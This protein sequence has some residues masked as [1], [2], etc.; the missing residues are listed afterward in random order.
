MRHSLTKFKWDVIGLSE[1]KKEGKEILETESY[2]MI[3][4]GEKS[5]RNGVGF[6][7]NKD[8]K[9]N[10]IDIRCISDRVIRLDIFLNNRTMHLIQCYAPTESATSEDLEIFYKHLQF[11][12]EDTGNDTV[13]MGDFNSK[14]GK[15]TAE[16]K[17]VMGPWGF[18][19]RNERGDILLQ[20]CFENQLYIANSHFKKNPKQK[21]TWI[22]PNGKVRNEIDFILVKN[23]KDV[24]NVQVINT[25]FPTDHRLIRVSMLQNCNKTKSRR[26]YRCK[27]SKL[28][29]LELES[30]K[31]VF[32]NHISN[33]QCDDMELAYGK[34]IKI[35]KE[36]VKALPK[37]KNKSIAPLS[38]Y[39]EKLINERNRLKNKENKTR[40]EKKQLSALYRHVNK[41]IQRDYKAHRYSVIEEELQ[42]RA[43]VKRA[44]VRLNTS[45]PWIM[46]LKNKENKT[47]SN[48]D[49]LIGAATQFYKELYG[50]EGSHQRT[51]QEALIPLSVVPS[52][53]ESE[54]RCAIQHLKSDK[55]PGDDGITNDILKAIIDPLVP[56]LTS[57][58]NDMLTLN[59]VPKEWGISII[60]LLYKKGDP[61]DLGNYRPISLQQTVYKVFAKVLLNR[62]SRMLDSNQPR[63]QAGFRR[64]YSTIDHIFTLTQLIEKFSEYGKKLYVAFIDYCKAFDS[65]KHEP[66]WLALQTQGV[67]NR[68]IEILKEIYKNSKAVVKLEGK[69]EPFD[70]RRGVKQGDPISPNLF[71][72]LLEYIF[73]QLDWE[74]KG[75][76]LNG[77]YLSNLRFADDIVLISENHKDLEY[78]L[79]TL[80]VESRKCGLQMNKQKTF[81]MTNSEKTPIQTESHSIC[82]VDEYVYLGQN[83]SF[84]NQTSREVERR[85]K[86][87]WNKY[88]SL[89]EIFKSKI[90]MHLKRK[91]MDT[92]VMPTLL[93]GCQTWSFTKD[94]V[95][96][97]NV[98]QRAAERSML[99][100]RLKDRKKNTDIRSITK[101]TDAVEL[102]SRLKWRWAGHTARATDNRWSEKILH[103]YPYEAK[104]PRGR[105]R[106]RWSDDIH[107]VA[108][109]TWTRQAQ[110]RQH[111]KELEEAYAQKWVAQ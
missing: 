9:T 92:V 25:T 51:R 73:R 34:L 87:A 106:R 56:I 107:Q 11:A 103:W 77:E 60:T 22:S 99:G 67:E 24:S 38:A 55:S 81:A 31:N 49:C 10:I 95:Q 36:S 79:N 78:M 68:Y 20:F 30:L 3:Y 91:A 48:R 58:F 80:D 43:S 8:L 13:V 84:L 6:L 39:V 5:G 27:V 35:I 29:P 46:S 1:V 32:A 70:I 85:I 101:I 75:I 102:A 64:T 50:N 23:I 14:I 94:I 2:I 33:F 42:K 71:T 40:P 61:A 110:D 16:D 63:E 28:N 82:Y 66:L 109:S 89:K 44:Q 72:A 37:I 62:I 83:I 26:D 104:R 18:G 53:I 96:K 108:G 88:W 111:W 93:Y 69:G 76:N 65:I 57:L 12:L 4:Y 100:I 105:P 54:V 21:W 15:P 7:V 97:I 98:F 52:I 41:Q 45:K 59:K 19:D 90:P 74:N 47:T 86:K 17:K